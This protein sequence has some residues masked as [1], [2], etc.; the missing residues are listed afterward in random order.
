MLET[1]KYLTQIQPPRNYRNIDSLNNV[2]LYLE[3]RFKV[4]SKDYKIYMNVCI[5][6]CN[7]ANKINTF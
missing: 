5:K 1:L 4:C 7:K 3:D 2:A 6:V